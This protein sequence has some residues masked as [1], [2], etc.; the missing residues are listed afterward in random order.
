MTNIPTFKG[1][2][3]PASAQ[4]FTSANREEEIRRLWT[5]IAGLKAARIDVGGISLASS[6]PPT[7]G[8]DIT[9]TGNLTF[10]TSLFTLG[11]VAGASLSG[12][13]NV[14]VTTAGVQLDQAA[15][16]P[17][18]VRWFD[19]GALA[20]VTLYAE[21]GF[22][23]DATHRLAKDIGGRLVVVGNDAPAVAAGSLG[24]VDLTAQVANIAATALSNT[25][26]AGMYEVEVYILTTTADVTA[27]TLAVAIGYT[28]N[29][30]A[31][32]QTAIAAHALTAT[33]RSTGRAI[34]RVASGDVTYSVTVTGIYGT[35]A[36]A[37]YARVVSLG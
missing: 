30:G 11:L 20:A 2:G 1:G 35:S 13:P 9:F 21:A 34:V 36:F 23:G 16:T 4:D 7:I 25:P 5:F 24:K 14:S 19:S 31:T 37:V 22:T 27:G 32:S 33:G 10:D 28:D 8:G 15:A 6:N 18:Y 3:N 26:P 12:Q 17:L 29:V